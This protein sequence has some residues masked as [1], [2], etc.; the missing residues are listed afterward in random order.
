MQAA[1]AI[2]QHQHLIAKRHITG[3]LNNVLQPEYS[4][5]SNVDMENNNHSRDQRPNGS[6]PLSAWILIAVTII[7]FGILHVFGGITLLNAS[8]AVHP[9]TPPTAIQGD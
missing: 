7:G 1:R 5:G 2:R 8:S 3:P 4:T 9:E 6:M